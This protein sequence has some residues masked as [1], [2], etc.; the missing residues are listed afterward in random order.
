MQAVMLCRSGEESSP[1]PE[2]DMGHSTANARRP[3]LSANVRRER[4]H[5]F[6]VHSKC[7]VCV[8]PPLANLASSLGASAAAVLLDN[9]WP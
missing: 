1:P 6:L 9:E 3:A 8:C 7:N 2:P 5:L 4:A